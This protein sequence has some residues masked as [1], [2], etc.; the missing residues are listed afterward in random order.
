MPRANVPPGRRSKRSCSSASSWRAANF[1]CCATS[2]RS[3]P[4]SSRARCS[5]PPTLKATSVIVATLQRAVLGRAGIAPA[6]LVC[7]ALLGNALAEP[8]LDAQREP[9][10]LGRRRRN[11][12]EVADQLA[13]ALDIALPVADLA[14]LEQR[15]GLV[16]LD[17]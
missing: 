2:L 15:V 17:S 16:G 7:V 10:R 12:V 9:Q 3:S 14:E 11:L 4:R 13:R 5:S 1:S 8:A 6:Q